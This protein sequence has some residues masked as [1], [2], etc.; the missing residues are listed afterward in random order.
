MDAIEIVWPGGAHPFRLRLGELRRLQDKTGAGPEELLNRVRLGR[1]KV[2]DLIEILRFG[3][4]GGGMGES[5]AAPLVVKMMELHPLLEF[6]MP[7]ELVLIYALLQPEDDELGKPEAGEAEA[8][9]A[10]G[11]PIPPGDGASPASTETGQ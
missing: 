11:H 5:D 8:R 1:W 9:E 3:L 6:K 4:I 2:D 7:A 10:G